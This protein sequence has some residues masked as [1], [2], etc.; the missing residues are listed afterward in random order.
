MS[1]AHHLGGH[2]K[3]PHWSSVSGY[4]HCVRRSGWLFAS[5]AIAIENATAPPPDPPRHGGRAF[6]AYLAVTFLCFALAVVFGLLGMRARDA[7]RSATASLPSKPKV[8]RDTSP[9]P[10]GVDS[11]RKV[12]PTTSLP[13]H[14]PVRPAIAAPET[15]H[16]LERYVDTGLGHRT[17]RPQWAF[18]ISDGNHS[19]FPEL[20]DAAAEAITSAGYRNV[21]L[22]R[23]ALVR[24]G[25]LE[26]LYAADPVLLKRLGPFCDGVIVAVAEQ[27][28]IPDTG[29]QGLLTVEIA[30]RV[31]VITT[32]SGSIR[33]EFSVLERGAGFTAHEA[34][35]NA[36]ERAAQDLRRQLEASF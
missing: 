12:T 34:E 13:T 25:K 18:V 28:P 3:P 29:V 23:P 10:T 30:V 32:P 26:D 31:R 19:A 5:L 21:A 16:F 4:G 14:A 1:R 11:E 36:R 17:D 7:V 9:P 22:F 15:D 33:K 20:G 35:R 2:A 27:T 6:T 24:D 8:Q